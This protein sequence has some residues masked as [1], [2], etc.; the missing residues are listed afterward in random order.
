[1]LAFLDPTFGKKATEDTAGTAE[2]AASA[3]TP[4]G[5]TEHDA[6]GSSQ[7]LPLDDV[8]SLFK[9]SIE[10]RR[11]NIFAAALN[12]RDTKGRDR[13]HMLSELASKWGHV[14]L[15]EK[16]EGIRKNCP[17]MTYRKISL[18]LFARRRA[19]SSLWMMLYRCSKR[20]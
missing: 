10:D 17:V 11:K 19:R 8:I 7:E 12:L 9:E 16:R 20:A 14:K 15:R 5:A 18:E 3:D 6:V 13:K 2:S 1:M 4:V